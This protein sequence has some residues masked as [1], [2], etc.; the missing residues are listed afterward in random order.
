MFIPYTVN[1]VQVLTV[2]THAQFYYVFQS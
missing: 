2:L 1:D